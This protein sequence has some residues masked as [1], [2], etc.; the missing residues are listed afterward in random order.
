MKQLTEA[1]LA[2][3]LKTAYMMGFQD[4]VSEMVEDADP[5]EFVDLAGLDVQLTKWVES[6]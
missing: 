5:D 6:V 2:E 3:M 1:K 4:G